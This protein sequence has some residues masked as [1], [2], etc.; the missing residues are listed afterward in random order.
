MRS[1]EKNTGDRRPEHNR[2]PSLS[3]PGTA[4]L[5]GAAV[6]PRGFLVCRRLEAPDAT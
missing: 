3:T 4:A 1:G 2:S 6:R 5:A